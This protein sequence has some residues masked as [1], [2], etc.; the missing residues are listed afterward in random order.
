MCI[1][2]NRILQTT[3]EW[4]ESDELPEIQKISGNHH[5]ILIIVYQS[6]YKNGEHE[7]KSFVASESTK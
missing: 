3:I 7:F 2:L 1:Y 6:R 4:R 5:I